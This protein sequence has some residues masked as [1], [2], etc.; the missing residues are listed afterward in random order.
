MSRGGS[1]MSKRRF[2]IKS[3][4]LFLKHRPVRICLL[5]ITTLFLGF[6]QGI[7]IVLLI[8]LLQL[9]SPGK[10]LS[11]SGNWVPVLD[12]MLN[13]LD[14]NPDIELI[15]SVFT[16]S[17][18]I[19]AFLTY[20]Q[21]IGQASYQQDFSFAMRKRLFKKIITSDWKFLSGKSR[22][23]H[24]QLLTTEIPKMATYYYYYLNLAGKVIFIAAHVV[25]ALMLSVRFTLLVVAVGLLLFILLRKYLRKAEWLGNANIQAFRQM[26]KRID[27]FW[28]VVKVA[29][30][31]HSEEFY[32][33]KFNETNTR[34][35][36]Y[37][38]QQII[39]RA[40]PQLLFSLAGI[41]LLAAVVYF[42][43]RFMQIR[44]SSLFVLILL[45]ARIFPRFT[46]INSDLNMMISNSGS[47][48][49]ILD[50]DKELEESNLTNTTDTRKIVLDRQITISNL[51]FGYDNGHSLFSNFNA[52]IPAKKMTGI[53][54]PS[55]SGKTTLIDIISGLLETNEPVL[56]VDNTILTGKD[57]PAWKSSLGYLPQDP[58]FIDGTLRENLVW[59]TVHDPDDDQIMETLK[60]VNAGHL[61]LRQKHGLDTNI[62][63]YQ[64]H[65]SGGERQRLALAR[66]LL[67]K[68]QLLLLDEAT[69]SLDPENE[70]RIMECLTQ[71]KTRVTIVFVTHRQNLKPYFDN[72]MVITDLTNLSVP[73]S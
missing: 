29:K 2:I 59:D 66:V 3:F 61:V 35:L 42:A 73:I 62:V 46:G 68:P 52:I 64:Y 40:V 51:S 14:I 65:F 5:F 37:Q 54:G 1:C 34:M 63:N 15:L 17:L 50:A 18:F 4:S 43:W 36:R 7:T 38:D 39:N 33:D 28:S 26:L 45:F 58:F 23:N 22:H 21:S 30:V 69:S 20:F 25:L 16:L 32:L 48:Q 13:K 12:N 47:V 11:G 8:P 70:A 56:A 19:M 53:I 27:E 71:L 10:D 49:I 31:H 57:L 6:N 72:I 55:G 67:R 24:I 60:Q 9:I 41:A 44:L